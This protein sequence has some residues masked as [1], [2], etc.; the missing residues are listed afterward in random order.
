MSRQC[1]SRRRRDI[2]IKC[3]R[4]MP[5]KAKGQCQN[6]WHKWKRRNIPEFY[7]SVRYTELKQRCVHVRNDKYG[8]Y[9]GKEYCTLE[10][11]KTFTNKDDTFIN[12]FNKWKENKHPFKLAPSIDRIDSSKGY[13][14]GNLQ[15]ITHSENSLKSQ[16]MMKVFVY[17][18]SDNSYVGVYNSQ[19]EAARRLGL[20]QANIQKVIKG[21][22]KHTGGYIFREE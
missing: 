9:I 18:K 3:E 10:E 14:L 4:F 6:C 20:H 11:F 13:I 2:C 15:W 5:I 19:S 17:L 1:E 16:N 22:R 8:R 21:T 12:L 7:I